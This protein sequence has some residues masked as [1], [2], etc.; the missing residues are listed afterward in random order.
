MGLVPTPR[1]EAVMLDDRTLSISTP[2]RAALE[3]LMAY[4]PGDIAPPVP[5]ALAEELLVQGFV[6]E[7]AMGGVHITE[8]GRLYV[9]DHPQ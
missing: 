3:G 5:F 4:A 1:P 7:S 9:R 2:A 6:Q 8:L